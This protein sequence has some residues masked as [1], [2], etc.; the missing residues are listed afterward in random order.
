MRGEVN[1]NV[2]FP[3]NPALMKLVQVSINTPSMS[4]YT[5]ISEDSKGRCSAVFKRGIAVNLRSIIRYEKFGDLCTP[6]RGNARNQS[7]RLQ[8]DDHVF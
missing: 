7:T 5:T 1:I 3:C 4:A 2:G 8:G 6:L